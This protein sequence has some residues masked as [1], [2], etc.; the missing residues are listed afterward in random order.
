[1][2][3][4]NPGAAGRGVPRAEINMI[5]LIDVMLVLLVI[6]MITA[7]LLT[8]A[9]KLDLPQASAQSSAAAEKV[10][11]AVDA[12]GTLHWDGT[13]LDRPQLASRLAELGRTRPKT[14]IHLH[15]D[16]S[17]RYETVAEIMAQA[18]GAGL[19]RIGFVTQPPGQGS[20]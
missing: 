17:S 10:E 8:H 9:V 20:R 4:L 7:P 2:A 5:P 6:F 16:K 18:A 15:V 12:A 3:F 13:A 1:M 14:E 19:V 11:I